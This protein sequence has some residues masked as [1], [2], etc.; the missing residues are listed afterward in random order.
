VPAL[1][2]AINPYLSATGGVVA[3]AQL[4][5]PEGFPYP[6]RRRVMAARDHLRRVTAELVAERRKG[7]YRRD[8]VQALIDARDEETGEAMSDV[9][10]V[11]N[12]LTFIAA[13]HETTALS[14]TWSFYL[15]SLHPEIE[16]KVLAE[17]AAATGADGTLS[18]EALAGLG[19][20]RQ[21]ISEALRL[22]PAAPSLLRSP[23]VP[24]TIGGHKLKPGAGIF[25]PVYAI[26]RHQSF[27]SDPDRFDPDRFRPDAVKA[28]PR[29]VYLP[30]AGGPRV[31]IGMGFALLEAVAILA[32]LLPHFRFEPAGEP[33]MPIAQTTLRPQAMMPVRLRHRR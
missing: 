32:R 4:G 10:I 30:F 33:P 17:I 13:G 1:A 26:H 8:I 19:Y 16:A 23:A 29:Y 12:L 3:I 31:C 21:V 6:G 14:L 24:V 28:R 11:D 18:P 25:I 15:L 9:E 22:Y 5:L 7:G 20:T 27:W 2:V